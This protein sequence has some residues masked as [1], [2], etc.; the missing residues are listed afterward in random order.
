MAVQI[1]TIIDS[2]VS[3]WQSNQTLSGLV[4]GGLWFGQVPES[5]Q[6]PYAV[7]SISPGEV[8]T[9]ATRDYLQFILFEISVYSSEPMSSSD[10]KQIRDGM[11]STYC[12]TSPVVSGARIVTIDPSNGT[13]EMM[14]D[15]RNSEDVL[16][17]KAGFSMIV[18][19]TF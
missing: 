11:N 3:T 8:I 9:T 15:R 1:E 14:P 4:P 2:L 17:S 19:G 16:A 18:Q 6:S 13:V 10:K 12:Q 7:I 5:T